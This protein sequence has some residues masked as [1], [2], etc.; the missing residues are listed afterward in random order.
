MD[1]GEVPLILDV[2]EPHEYEI[3]RLPDSILIP[4]GQIGTR[5]HELDKNVEI[6]VHCKMGGRSDK[7]VD[8]MRKAGFRNVRNMVGGINRWAQKV[9]AT[10]PRY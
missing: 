2:R 3:C 7:A 5:M 10:M 6:V 4:L 8:Q 9:D 1:R